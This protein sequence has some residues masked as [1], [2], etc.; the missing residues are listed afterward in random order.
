MKIIFYYQKLLFCLLAP[1]L[2]FSVS[3]KAQEQYVR[4]IS[5]DSIPKEL[6]DRIS[7]NLKDVNLRE[8]LSEISSQGDFHLNYADRVIPEINISVKTADI[9]FNVLKKIL[10]GTDIIIARSGNGEIALVNSDY[11]KRK[12][13]RFTISG[14]IKDCA[15]GEALTGTNVYEK[16]LRAGCS[17]NSYGFYS[18]DLPSGVYIIK[19]S[20]MGYESR[21]ININLIRDVRQDIELKEIVYK[22][23]TIII[24][25][26]REETNIRSSEIGT[27]KIDPVRQNKIPVLF[28]EQDIIKSIQLLPGVAQSREGDCGFFVRGGNSDQN[29]VLMDEA[30]V[31]NAYHLLGFFSVF[32][33]DALKDVKLIKGSGSAKYGGRL[34]SVLDIQM[35]EGNSKKFS[36]SGGIGLAFSRLTLQGPFNKGKGSYIFSGRRT[37]ADLFLKLSSNDEV[38]DSRLVFYDYNVKANYKLG[39]RDRIFLS[40]YWGKDALGFRNEFD[41]LWGNKTGTLRWN[42]IFNGK[43]FS[44]TSLIYSNFKYNITVKEEKEYEDDVEESVSL[45]S[46]VKDVNFKNDFQLF[47]NKSN[48]LNFGLNYIYY[49]FLP[50]QLSI[51]DRNTDLDLDVK[52]RNAHEGAAYLSHEISPADNFTAEYGLRYSLFSVFG[53]GDLYYM[54]DNDE[55]VEFESLN[56][57]KKNYT[58]IEPRLT[59]NYIINENN[60]IKAGYARNYQ[61]IHQLSNST[62][63]TPLD[64]WQ[65]SSNVIKPQ[66]SDQVSL[67]Y[68]RNFNKN[69][70]KASVEVYYKDMK[71]QIDFKN[72]AQLFV[73][74]FIE[75]ELAFGKGWAYGAEFLIK[76]DFG[77]LTGWMGYTCSKTIRKF[78]EINNGNPFP[79]R[80]DRTH[81]F[82]FVSVYDINDKWSFSA[83][84]VYFTGNA[85]TVPIGKFRLAGYEVDLFTDRN[86]YRMPAYHRLDIGVNYST[87]SNSMWNFSLYNAYGKK[88]VYSIQFRQHEYARNVNEAVKLSL[89]SFFP[90]VTYNKK[91]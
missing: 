27:I 13:R 23:E 77:K 49:T 22:G 41:I 89:F 55:L 46:V 25:G 3:L 76:K 17:S 2:I 18:L 5:E 37:Y 78:S 12:R 84:W 85:V 82:S 47:I 30:P 67:G 28:G 91:F 50:C 44:N 74:N 59:L 7:V 88:N 42:H 21:E 15:S 68:F 54:D 53:P 45:T 48:V 58:G 71:N 66:R 69:K 9:I 63:G 81:D 8:A 75:S 36:G 72:G 26:V 65:P 52:Y 10:D 6:L 33:S 32:N 19:I 20:Y 29:L 14:Y 79:A 70:Y 83:N 86:G 35:K 40:G 73:S 43:L 64:V 39:D 62:S 90:S 38:K 87:N 34:S 4:E 56:E 24:T 11:F 31:Y 61:N 16:N 1:V 57:K 80:Y 60:S 51:K